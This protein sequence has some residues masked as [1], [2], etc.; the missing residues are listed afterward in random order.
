MLKTT[1]LLDLA[2]RELGTDEI[3]GGDAKADKTVID[4]FKSSKS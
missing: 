2:P 3:V 4:S 1:R